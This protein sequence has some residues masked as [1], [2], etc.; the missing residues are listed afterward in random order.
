M[1]AAEEEAVTVFSVAPVV[2]AGAADIARVAGMTARELH[3]S[4]GLHFGASAVRACYH[5]A[6]TDTVAADVAAAAVAEAA[7]VAVEVR[8][9]VVATVAAVVVGTAGLANVNAN[10][11]ATAMEMAKE[12][13]MQAPCLATRSD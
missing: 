6:H 8:D 3:V 1:A 4:I 7:A 12:L 10:A 13:E 5:A 11:N 2:S 9:D